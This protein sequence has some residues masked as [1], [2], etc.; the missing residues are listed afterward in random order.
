MGPCVIFRGEARETRIDVDPNVERIEA[1]AREKE[2]DKTVR[3]LTLVYLP[4]IA[5]PRYEEGFDPQTSEYCSTWNL[6]YTGEQVDELAG[7]AGKNW[8]EG[9]D[10]VRWELRRVWENKRKEREERS[11][12]GITEPTGAKIR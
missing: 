9:V 5:N 2:E 12:F 8:A 10:R 4:L 11:E 7:L 3:A 6:V 1:E